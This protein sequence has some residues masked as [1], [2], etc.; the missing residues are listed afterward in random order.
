MGRRTSRIAEDM[1]HCGIRS[2]YQ[3]RNEMGGV[4]KMT[5][6]SK[7]DGE[8]MS[9]WGGGDTNEWLQGKRREQKSSGKRIDEWIAEKNTEGHG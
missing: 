7:L 4:Q 2:S 5:D 6:M 8:R 3:Y 1:G 9:R